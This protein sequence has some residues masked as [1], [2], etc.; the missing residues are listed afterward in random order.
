MTLN[1]QSAA[2]ARAAMIRQW[3]RRRDN[4]DVVVL[5]ETSKGLGTQIIADDLRRR[6]YSVLLT[7]DSRD[8]GVLF[9]TRQP[10]SEVLN[11]RLDVTLP[12]RVAAVVLDTVPRVAVVG[13]YVPSRDRSEFKVNRKREFIRSLL[14]GLWALPEAMRQHLVLAGD[15]NVVPR[16]HKPRLPGFF[17]YEYEM[18]E[19]LSGYGLESVHT[20]RP[21]SAQPH[22]W[23][24]RT[25]NGYLYDYVHLGQAL[26]DRLERYAYLHG[27]RLR[28]LSDHAAL[29]ARVRLD[30]P[31]LRS[32]GARTAAAHSEANR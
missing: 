7:P 10:V 29:V 4:D 11:A 13:V 17:P 31:R 19:T 25:G 18:H 32:S 21:S 9:A 8:R 2:P 22:S 12:W 5:T 26:H 1:I 27:P 20:L 28:G 30:D 3:L 6:G 23:I 16:D 15:Y 14:I 24:G